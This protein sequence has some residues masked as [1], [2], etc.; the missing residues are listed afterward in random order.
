VKRLNQYNEFIQFRSSNGLTDVRNPSKD[1]EKRLLDD[2][3]SFNPDIILI[4]YGHPWQ[5][6][7]IAQHRNILSC[8][9]AIG[10]GGSFD[11]I[12][13]KVTR[14]PVWMRTLGLEWVFRLIS[15]PRRFMR[16]VRATYVFIKLVVSS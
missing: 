14:A 10:V 7:W 2:I 8:R 4:A 1:E 11:Y 5:D 3:S 13:Q 6:M 9:V 15:Q 16:V 12:A